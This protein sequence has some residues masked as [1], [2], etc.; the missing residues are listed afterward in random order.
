MADDR[1]QVLGF[2]DVSHVG[3]LD[4]I[5]LTPAATGA[6]KALR[7]LYCSGVPLIARALL[8]AAPGPHLCNSALLCCALSAMVM[9]M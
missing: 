9:A 6:W 5:T 8:T 3:H 1:R 2:P 7:G 4:Q